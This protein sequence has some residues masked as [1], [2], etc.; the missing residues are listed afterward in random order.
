[1]NDNGSERIFQALCVLHM[2]KPARDPFR[3]LL[4][5]YLEQKRADITTLG[6]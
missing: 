5:G 2:R 1:M 3:A 6:S 4:I